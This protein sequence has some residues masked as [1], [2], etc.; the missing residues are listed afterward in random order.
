[1][2]KQAFE[3]GVVRIPITELMTA[4]TADKI[5]KELAGGLCKKED[6]INA[7]IKYPD[8]YDLLTA[9]ALDDDGD[10]CIIQLGNNKDKQR[11]H[12]F[13]GD[14]LENI[15]KLSDHQ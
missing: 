3:K 7:G 13:K 1:M 8:Y 4:S 15:I 12:T 5:A 11:Y 14:M 2:L 10:K 6:F 9:Y